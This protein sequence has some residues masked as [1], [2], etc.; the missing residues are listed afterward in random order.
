MLPWSVIIVNEA[1]RELKK[2]PLHIKNKFDKWV[3]LVQGYG[4]Y[5][6]GGWNTEQ[7]KGVL[8]DFY[9]IR[10]NRKWRV[11]FEIKDNKNIIVIRIVPH[12]YKRIR[13]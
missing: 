11:I 8:K 5:L 13:K 10:L 9:S 6:K 1:E 4:P 3:V 2:A 12:E 7:L